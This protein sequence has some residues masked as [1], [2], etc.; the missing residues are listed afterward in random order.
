MLSELEIS[1]LW[2]EGQKIAKK[3]IKTCYH[4]NCNETSI[5]S[6][7][8]QKNGII[9][10]ISHNGHVWEKKINQFS[11]KKFY[12]EKSGLNKVFSF[13][14]FCKTHDK[15]L[16]KIIEDNKIDFNNYHSCLLF[17]LRTLYNEIYRKQVIVE[18][19][20]FLMKSDKSSK[21]NLKLLYGFMHQQ[22]LGINDLE[23]NE[24]DI[25]EDYFHNTQNFIFQFREMNKI[26]ICLS[27]FYNYET[28]LEMI[29]YRV[30]KGKDMERVSEVFINFFPYEKKSI[31]LMGY[32]KKDEK[33]LKPYINTFF[34]E[35]DSKVQT[36][37][38]NLLMFACES[39]IIS[40]NL[41]KTKIQKVEDIFISAV[42]YAIK[43]NNERE[44][45]KVNIFKDNFNSEMQ[46]LKRHLE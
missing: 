41:Y 25:W 40:E 43:N 33:K 38:T 6:H 15:E 39:W 7:I 24:A 23:Q 2:I 9:N 11:N 32:N 5:N 18:Q 27:A 19:I 34:K 46:R 42:E 10:Q 1:N 8:L 14:C 36:K 30:E 4:P 37:I 45:F 26:D 29:N 28:T 3:K 17:T 20:K 31:L 35:S 44:F 21:L 22:L 12:F 16:F 13:N